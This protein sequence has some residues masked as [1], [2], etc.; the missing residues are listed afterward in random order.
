[1]TLTASS[2]IGSLMSIAG[3]SAPV[4]TAFTPGMASASLVSIDTMRAWA[5]GERTIAP[6][7]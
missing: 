1:M 6:R 2:W 5:Y 7:S 4:T 3:K